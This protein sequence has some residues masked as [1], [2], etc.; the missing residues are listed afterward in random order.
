MLS[1]VET[2]GI[3]LA[4]LPLFISAFEHYND[5]LEPLKAFWDID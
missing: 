4:V 5:S 1:G 2:A 3:I